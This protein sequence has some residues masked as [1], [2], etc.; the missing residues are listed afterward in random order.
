MTSC[1][2]EESTSNGVTTG[3]TCEQAKA[4]FQDKLKN[5]SNTAKGKELLRNYQ[6]AYPNCKF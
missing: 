2:K 4:K 1:S 3:L 5:I 6:A